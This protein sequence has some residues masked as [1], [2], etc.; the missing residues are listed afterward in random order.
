MRHDI[1]APK[2]C[3]VL[4]LMQLRWAAI[5]IGTAGASRKG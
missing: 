4:R 5:C 1:G 2:D 3:A